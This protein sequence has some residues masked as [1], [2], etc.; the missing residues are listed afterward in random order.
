MIYAWLKCRCIRQPS[1]NVLSIFC[2]E[3]TQCIMGFVFSLTFTLITIISYSSLC[4]SLFIHMLTRWQGSH[5]YQLVNE[6]EWLLLRDRSHDTPLMNQINFDPVFFP[7]SLKTFINVIPCTSQLVWVC[8]VA[9]L[10]ASLKNWI[11]HGHVHYTARTVS[12]RLAL[13]RAPGDQH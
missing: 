11:A 12:P 4:D 9:I 2:L 13:S 7:V 1:S 3:A 5:W 6:R 10:Q 8:F